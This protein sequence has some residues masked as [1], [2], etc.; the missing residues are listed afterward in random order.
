MK[1][2]LILG[3]AAALAFAQ[4]PAPIPQSQFET[5]MKQLS[6]WGRWGKD[7]ERGAINL[8]TP[9]KRVAASKLVREGV[10]VSLSHDA[11]TAVA[12]DNPKPFL[13][14]MLSTAAT[15]NAQAHSDSFSI[16]HHGLAH[17][18]MDSLCHFFWNEQMY[19]GTPRAVVT[20]KGASKLSIHNLKG[21]IYTRGVLM[22][23]PE[24]EGLPWLEPGAPVLPAHLDAWEKKAG[25]KVSAGDVLLIRTG[26]WARRTAKGAWSGQ[27]AGLH[28]STIP[29][30]KSR[31]IAVLGSD[32]ASDVMP[33][34]VEGV[35]Q[36]IHI[37][38]L[39]ALGANILDNGDY[40]ELSKACKQ[41]KRWEFLVT[42]A[43]LAVPGATGSALN[44]VAV[45]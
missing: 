19:N 1:A 24:L 14:E 25:I 38:T 31:D 42:M 44:P 40:E 41:R 12:A 13:H 27:L 15:P 7:D 32:A 9:A 2:T 33:S 17:T 29:W 10:T 26:R 18:H 37:F 28:A 21:G 22:D 5:W 39:V 36:P 16:S 20:A 30:L 11:E 23:I 35:R 45:F 4:S 34:G 43:P 3:L 6:N 8:I